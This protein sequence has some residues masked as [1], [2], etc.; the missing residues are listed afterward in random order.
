M[1]SARIMDNLDAAVAKLPVM[2]SWRSPNMDFL[3]LNTDTSLKGGAGLAFGGGLIR[4][5][6]GAWRAG[7]VANVGGCSIL[8]EEIWCL[9]HG[10]QLA[11]NLGIRK[12]VVESDSA[13]GVAMI[14]GHFE[15]TVN[16]QNIVRRLCG[17]LQDFESVVVQHVHRKDNFAADFLSHYAYSAR[18][19]V[20]VLDGP[21]PGMNV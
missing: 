3:K 20:H 5:E 7:F 4:D 6:L 21:P 2:I 13:V 16:C 12:L 8:T 1:E 9:F 10:V 14:M 17:L 18:K 19:G 11:K 15:V